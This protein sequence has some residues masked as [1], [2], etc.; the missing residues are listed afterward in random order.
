MTSDQEP[1]PSPNE[2]VTF[3]SIIASTAGLAVYDGV[4]LSEQAL[5][6]IADQV[7]AGRANFNTQHNPLLGLRVRNIRAAQVDDD[8]SGHRGV[9]ITGEIARGDLTKLESTRGWSIKF[10]EPIERLRPPQGQSPLMNIAGD[11]AWYDDETIAMGVMAATNKLAEP[12]VDASPIVSGSRL[13]QFSAQHANTVMI[14]YAIDLYN[15]LGPNLIASA[16]WDGIKALW[17][18]R[19]I[20]SAYTSTAAPATSIEITCEAGDARTR[21]YLETDDPEVARYALDKFGDATQIMNTQSLTIWDTTSAPHT[22]RLQAPDSPS[23]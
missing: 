13:Y 5:T 3:N 14:H 6:Q 12:A 21:A 7:N 17:E 1:K 11:A 20:P 16:I 8:G 19:K 23:E 9:R 2:W 22:W 4:R 15:A 18:N 10:S